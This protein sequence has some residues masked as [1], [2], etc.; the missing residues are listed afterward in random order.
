MVSPDFGFPPDF[1]DFG[2]SD[3]GENYLPPKSGKKLGGK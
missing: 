3:F 1:P 2:I